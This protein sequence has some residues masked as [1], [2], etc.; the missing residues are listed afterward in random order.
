MLKHFAESN[1]NILFDKINKK[2][3]IIGF[4]HKFLKKFFKL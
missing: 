1:E 3:Q 2:F 4:I